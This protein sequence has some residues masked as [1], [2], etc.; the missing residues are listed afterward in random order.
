M[1]TWLLILALL[2]I[3]PPSPC[4]YSMIGGE[5]RQTSAGARW[6]NPP[7][8]QQS[9]VRL[10]SSYMIHQA[11]SSS[12]VQ[13]RQQWR[14]YPHMSTVHTHTG[15]HIARTG[16]APVQEW[17]CPNPTARVLVILHAKG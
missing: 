15:R 14:R 13:T 9:R 7:C 12:P 2:L 10:S 8:H 4:K 17:D 5:T 16:G 1:L 11:H 3:Y 6:M